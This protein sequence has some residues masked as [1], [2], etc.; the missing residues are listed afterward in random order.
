MPKII[1]KCSYLKGA[2]HRSFYTKYMA[3]REGAEKINASYGKADATAKQKAM[4]SQILKDFPDV[5]DLFEFE[6]YI[7]KP[8]RENA[9]ELISSVMENNLE[10][11]ATK[12]NYVDYIAN[13]PRAEK[14]GEHGLFTDTDDPIDLNET[15]KQVAEHDGII[16]TNI[17]SIRREDAVR[18]GYDNAKAWINMCR[19]KRNELAEAI[20]IDSD[21]LKW[22]AAFHNEGHHPHIHMIVYSDDG[23]QGYLTKK[24]I[25]QLRSMYVGTIFKQELYHLYENK[26]KQRDEV[27]RVSRERIEELIASLNQPIQD[28]EQICA[29][30][31]VL[32]ES[33]QNYKGRLVYGFLKKEDKRLVDD[34]VCLLEKDERIQELYNAWYQTKQNISSVYKDEVDVKLPLHSQKEF[35]SIRNIIL[36][37]V[38][39]INMNALVSEE[40]EYC[41]TSEEDADEPIL[42]EYDEI[43]TERV[44]SE[45]YIMEW[46]E[47]YKKVMSLI[48]CREEEQDI[49]KAIDHLKYEA[50]RGN[51]LAMSELGKLYQKGIGIENDKDK[52]DDYYSSALAGFNELYHSEDK[53]HKYIAYRIGKFYLYGLGTEQNYEK[54]IDFFKQAG[55]NKYALY[56]LGMMAKRGLGMEQDDEF[57]FQYFCESADKGNAYAQYETA[58]ALEN[59]YGTEKN[60]EI[61]E[62]YYRTAFS[63][64]VQMEEKSKDDSLQYRLGKMCY[65]GK[66][67]AQDIAQAID[68]LEK[69]SMMKNEHSR[70]LLAKIWLK[71]NYFEH[72]EEARTMLE[73]LAEKENESA[74]FLL[75][76]EFV[77]GEHFEKDREKAIYYLKQCSE[78]GNQFADY[79]LYKIYQEEPIDITNML[80]YLDKCVNHENAAAQFQMG[81]IYL[82]GR[83]VEKDIDSAID[84]LKKSAGQNNMFAQYLLGKLF[85]YGSE[86]PRD[87]ELAIQYLE[88]SASQGNEYAKWLIEHKDECWRQ[89]M[90]LLVSRFFHHLSRTFERQ[91]LPS[92]NNP[93]FSIDH[94]LRKKLQ[95]KRTALGHKENDHTMNQER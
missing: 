26:S 71:E 87:E 55:N 95:M 89:P 79:K 33:I 77:T 52:A 85:F 19:A 17:I 30:L 34:I 21:K 73:E 41:D 18:L 92:A 2:K 1:V 37:E 42:M 51:V 94:K 90:V 28:N 58:I 40:T 63:G 8:N 16:W 69:S 56:S 62:R 49:E 29:K 83:Y 24:G 53:M 81:K 25:E 48:Y 39:E 27:K 84:Y 23:K 38:S 65:E 70:L 12:E 78:K 13:R 11:A 5:N 61:A 14:L 32:Y 6:D 74:L 50:E 68:Y 80:Y 45:S 46:N 76:K 4:I 10:I 82:E 67:T 75:G 15:A 43:Q 93:L 35:K 88:S 91:L 3:T 44:C 60:D 57:A 20:Q 7:R 72:F 31:M 36:Q 54:A 22:Y 9:S 64:F 66:G 86:V 59:G 47:I